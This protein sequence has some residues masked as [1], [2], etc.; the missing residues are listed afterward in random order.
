MKR[1]EPLLIREVLEMVQE[2]CD[3]NARLCQ[4][5]AIAAWPGIVGTWIADHSRCVRFDG[6]VLIIGV[7][8]ASLRQ[9]LHMMRKPLSEALSKVAGDPG[10][11]ADIRFINFSRSGSNQ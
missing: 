5:R 4:R 1:T 8:G 6:D 9:E 11:V 3:M 7:E 10:V 2:E